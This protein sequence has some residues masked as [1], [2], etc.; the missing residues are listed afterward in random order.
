M[1]VREGSWLQIDKGTSVCVCASAEVRVLSE[2]R[3]GWTALDQRVGIAVPLNSAPH[4]QEVGSRR[5]APVDR[6]FAVWRAVSAEEELARTVL[7]HA[8]P[9]RSKSR[10]LTNAEVFALVARG[11]SDQLLGCAWTVRGRC[12]GEEGDREERERQRGGHEEEAAGSGRG[13][14]CAAR[15]AGS[16][17]LKRDVFV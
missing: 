13:A 12:S 14:F 6:R 2:C 17:W 10:R 15:W 11:R 7:S 3:V 4:E 9:G 8:V 1:D 16:D 5:L